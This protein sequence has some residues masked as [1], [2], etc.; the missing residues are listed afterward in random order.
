MSEEDGGVR[1]EWEEQGGGGV[2][3]GHC[4][5]LSVA[6][7]RLLHSDRTRSKLPDVSRVAWRSGLLR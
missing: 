7:K 3:V 2:G 6:R 4:I 5:P 1:L